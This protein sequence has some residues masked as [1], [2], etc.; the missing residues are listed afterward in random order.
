MAGAT[1]LQDSQVSSVETGRKGDGKE[2]SVRGSCPHQSGCVWGSAGV[3]CESRAAGQGSRQPR[4]GPRSKGTAKREALG[5]MG[6][7]SCFHT[8]R[9]EST[10]IQTEA[11][12]DRSLF[13]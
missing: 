5:L 9:D 11:F 6:D 10:T 12:L 7:S 3:A 2:P 8:D 1:A 4:Q 13:H